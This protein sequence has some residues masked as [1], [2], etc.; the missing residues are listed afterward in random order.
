[1]GNLFAK[2]K[3]VIFYGV[4]LAGTLL[5]LKWLEFRFVIMDH[6]FEVYTG[7]I[8]LI[9]AHQPVYRMHGGER[10]FNLEESILNVCASALRALGV[11]RV[12]VRDL[13][14]AK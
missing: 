8:A 12:I 11:P 1:M 6:A 2:N 7:A 14:Q 4:L 3:L 13:L 9:D 5:L 10:V